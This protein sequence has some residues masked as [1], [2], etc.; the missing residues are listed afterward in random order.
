[1]IF[2]IRVPIGFVR[3]VKA[4]ACLSRTTQVLYSFWS[5]EVSSRAC[6]LPWQLGE[7]Q[8]PGPVYFEVSGAS[9]AITSPLAATKL[10]AQAKPVLISPDVNFTIIEGGRGWW[11]GGKLVYNKTSRDVA[12][13]G[14]LIFDDLR[15]IQSQY[16]YLPG[17]Q[18]EELS[19][20]TQTPLYRIHGVADFYPHFHF[21]PPPK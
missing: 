12:D 11:R 13:G 6:T 21:K 2:A 10:R 1:M 4:C 18:L 17:E 9:A 19:K 14:W 3:L 8:D 5:T 15:A 16:G 7:L 20:R